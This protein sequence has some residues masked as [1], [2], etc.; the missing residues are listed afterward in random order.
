[1]GAHK[2]YLEKHYNTMKRSILY[3]LIMVATLVSTGCREQFD[4]ATGGNSTPKTSIGEPYEVFVICNDNHWESYIKDVAKMVLEDEVP[5]L[6]RPEKF[7]HVVDHKSFEAVNDMERKHSNILAVRID[8]TNESTRHDVAKDVN[9][10]MQTIVTV[11][12]PSVERAA[13]YILDHGADI[14][15]S[16]EDNERA[17]HHKTVASTVSE[18][19]KRIAKEVTGLDIHIPGGFSVA[20]PKEDIMKWFVRKYDNKAQHI[21]IFTEP[22][23]DFNTFIGFEDIV[24]KRLNII[25][26]E[27]EEGTAMG[28]SKERP[29]YLDIKEINGRRWYEA[30]CCWTVE[31]YPLGG[32]MVC[33][34]TY[35]AE[36][37]QIITIVFALF[38]PEQMHRHDMAQL[39]SLI[40]LIK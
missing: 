23:E 36:R 24:D 31:G 17:I 3:L 16:F 32:S 2:R 25:S 21:F 22:C 11:H 33:Y 30:R 39:E 35:D 7:F 38:S 1:M 12:S 4:K 28:I 37:K 5:G 9:A 26:V 19:P 20:K 14:R 15:Q 6:V 18:E 13:E 10:T 29:F 8:A 27:D 40:Y 34:Y